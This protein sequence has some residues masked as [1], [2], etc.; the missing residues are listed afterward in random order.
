MIDWKLIGIIA[1]QF[2][3]LNK[4]SAMKEYGMSAETAAQVF[5]SNLEDAGY[6][7]KEKEKPEK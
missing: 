3:I 1:E 4:S 5:I 6:E 7:I 2:R